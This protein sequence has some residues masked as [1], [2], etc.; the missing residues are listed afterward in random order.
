M[1]IAIKQIAF[2][3]LF[4]TSSTVLLSQTEMGVLRGTVANLE[5]ELL[6]FV[7]VRLENTDIGTYSDIDGKFQIY[8]E[9]GDYTLIAEYI[10]YAP[11]TQ[12]GVLIEPEKITTYNLQFKEERIIRVET[13]KPIIYCYP[14]DT[15]SLHL[16]IDYKGELTTTYPKYPEAGWKVTAMPNGT[17]ID[18]DNKEYYALYWEGEPSHPLTISH[19]TVVTKENTIEFLEQRLEQLGLNYR[20]ANEFIIYWLPILERNPYNVISFS[21]E[22]YENLA[23]LNINPQP[24]QMI[25]VMMLYQGLTEPISIPAQE[26]IPVNKDRKGFT[27]VEWGGQEANIVAP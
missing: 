26:V 22:A 24:D 18:S 17:L 23:R 10:G 14:A 5:G 19:G 15:I 13:V 16:S 1:N 9:A 8:L 7:C 12:T 11:I 25:R 6:P 21:F 4:L 27:V 2:I 20:E 3:A